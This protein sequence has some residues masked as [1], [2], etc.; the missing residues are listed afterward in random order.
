VLSAIERVK[1]VTVLALSEV[2]VGPEQSRALEQAVP[3][4]V[5]E[6]VIVQ[7]THMRR[8]PRH[9]PRLARLRL[10]G[11][12]YLVAKYDNPRMRAAIERHLTAGAYDLVYLGHIG[13]AAY[14]ATVR[15]L[16]PRA[17]V[18]LE[19]HNVEWQIFARLAAGARLSLRPAL[20][21]EAR[22]LRRFERVVLRSVDATIAISE[23][24]AKALNSLAGIQPISVP[25]YI[26]PESRRA[27][28]CHKPALSYTGHLAWQPNT[29][30][31]DW[32][33]RDVW[34]GVR[35]Q[36]PDATLTIAGP[37]LPRERDGVITVPPAWQ[38]PGIATVGYVDDLEQLYGS[39]LAMVAP[40][41]GGSG[42]RMKLLEA[43]RAGMP[44]VTTTDG[45][46]GLDVTNG[47]EM[48]IA[49]QPMEFAEQV[50]RLLSDQSLREKIREAGYAYLKEH[51]SLAIARKRLEPV[52]EKRPPSRTSA[53][54]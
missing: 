49:D 17:H 25:T 22:T 37:G 48:L 45:A 54:P 27:E 40:I 28:T 47:R 19:E 8:S 41:L 29:L 26:E 1:K 18:I 4:V 20:D 7:P 39:S 35:R 42:V 12:P 43:M 5:A 14:L 32:F 46:A 13:M 15:R 50:V 31:L 33:C 23:A 36:V 6:E 51:H 24:D 10:Q 21:W 34:P 44:T 16:A 38:V 2:A 3:K 53:R 11:V 30:G 9:W 52:L